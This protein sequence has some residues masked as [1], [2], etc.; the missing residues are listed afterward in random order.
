M[1]LSFCATPFRRF[2]FSSGGAWDLFRCANVI[3]HEVAH[4]WY[5]N[6]VTADTW[7]DLLVNEGLATLLE[8]GCMAAVLPQ[9]V[10][11]LGAA[12]LMRGMFGG[13]TGV[14][15][16]V[17]EGEACLVLSCQSLRGGSAG[18]F[19]PSSRPCLAR[20]AGELWAVSH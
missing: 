8:Y 18:N 20:Q 7:A 1:P 17:H 5:G 16:G 2:L 19:P 11:S 4:Q 14:N 6:L 9:E 13:P 10:G 12:V 3:C 15:P